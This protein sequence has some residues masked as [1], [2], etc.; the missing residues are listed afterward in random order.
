MCFS[1]C[2]SSG[3]GMNPPVFLLFWTTMAFNLWDCSRKRKRTFGAFC[4]LSLRTG[5][6]V[7]RISVSW[8]ISWRD[9]GF[10]ANWKVSGWLFDMWRRSWVMCILHCIQQTLPTE[11]GYGGTG[12]WNSCGKSE[13]R[14]LEFE[15]GTV[16]S[17]KALQDKQK[18]A[19]KLTHRSPALLKPCSTQF[20]PPENFPQ[21][22][23]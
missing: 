14:N 3:L 20:P 9:S 5:D 1:F 2:K 23:S 16:C 22:E 4:T 8:K 6:C 13:G 19:S 21:I 17:V 15:S 10:G 18:I 12:N 7:G 11:K